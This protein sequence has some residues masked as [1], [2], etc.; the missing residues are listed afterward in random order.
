MLPDGYWT[1]GGRFVMYL[2]IF[3]VM[4]LNVEPPCC[5]PETDKVLY[6][7]YNS[8]LKRVVIGIQSVYFFH[9]VLATIWQW[10]EILNCVYSCLVLRGF[11]SVS[12]H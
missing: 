11:F 10:L 1:H 9:F 3:F 2:F 6:I 8:I 12:P 7:K 5:M 4:Y